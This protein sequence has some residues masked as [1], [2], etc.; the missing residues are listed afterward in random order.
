M[1]RHGRG[2]GP[3]GFL[4]GLGIGALSFGGAAAAIGATWKV[5]EVIV[6]ARQLF[7]VRSEN[8]VFVRLIE[9]V[10]IDLREVDRLLATKEVKEGLRH[11]KPKAIWIQ[12][13]IKDVNDAISE[14]HKYSRKV[15][16][17]GWWLGLKTRLWWILDE[18]NKLLH[19]EMELSAARE[20][21]LAVIE[22]LNEFDRGKGHAQPQQSSE[23]RQTTIRKNVDIDVDVDVDVDRRERRR[24]I[25]LDYEGRPIQDRRPHDHHDHIIEEDEYEVE[26]PFRVSARDGF[27]DGRLDGPLATRPSWWAEKYGVT[28]SDEVSANNTP[29]A[30]TKLTSILVRQAHCGGRKSRAGR[31]PTARPLANQVVIASLLA[32]L[33]R[34]TIRPVVKTP[35]LRQG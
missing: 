33:L 5:T 13:K 35:F 18:H 15:A 26:R 27:Y 16:E 24:V 20:G 25:E 22:Y 23:S 1:S 12:E 11:N 10:R 28:G 34:S 3:A 7:R 9:R 17:A 4:S 32:P 2:R 14:V 30:M 21:L 19:R 29:E 8:A 31:R 6:K